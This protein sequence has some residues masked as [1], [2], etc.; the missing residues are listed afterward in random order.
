MTKTHWIY[1]K[2]IIWNKIDFNRKA[3][4]IYLSFQF[5]LYIPINEPVQN[6]PVFFLKFSAYFYGN[7]FP[8]H[9]HV[10]E[11]QRAQH[12]LCSEVLSAFSICLHKHNIII[13]TLADEK[14]QRQSLYCLIMH[15]ECAMF[16][17]WIA[18]GWTPKCFWV[19]QLRRFRDKK[20]HPASLF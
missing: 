15:R 18:A 13:T 9:K 5:F 7:Y 1:Q 2:K 14:T 12:F 20:W 3:W 17:H 19:S 10:I 6:A 11:L 16:A 8:F 4:M